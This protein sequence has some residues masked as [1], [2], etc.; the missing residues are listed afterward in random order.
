MSEPLGLGSLSFRSTRLRA[1]GRMHFGVSALSADQEL[2][3]RA[4][5]YCPDPLLAF[6]DHRLAKMLGAH[7]VA[8]AILALARFSGT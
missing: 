2:N 3:G 8:L 4:G 6:P 1:L 5:T 7:V